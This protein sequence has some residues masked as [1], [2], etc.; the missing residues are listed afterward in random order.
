MSAVSG[1]LMVRA[2][3]LRALGG[4]DE[5]SASIRAAQVA[6][7]LS[8]S[9]AG[10]LVVWTPQAQVVRHGQVD[11]L[12]CTPQSQD[13]F[14]NAGHSRCAALFTLDPDSRVEWQALIA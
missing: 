6:A 1:C 12:A 3:V 7:C 11:E 8:V 5:Q 10:L 9:A 2:E 13:P 4:L 14:Y